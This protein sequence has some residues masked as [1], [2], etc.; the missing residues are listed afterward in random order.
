MTYVA[1]VTLTDGRVTADSTVTVT[2]EAGRVVAEGPVPEVA[3][4]PGWG[5]SKAGPHLIWAAIVQFGFTPCGTLVEA[6]DGV[7]KEWSRYRVEPL[8]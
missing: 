3:N 2:D 4:V 7:T 1:T 5:Q 6:S 8:Q